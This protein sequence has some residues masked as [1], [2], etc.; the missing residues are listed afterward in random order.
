V[1]SDNPY[2]N[3]TNNRFSAFGNRRNPTTWAGAPTTGDLNTIAG[4]SRQG[5]TMQTWLGQSMGLNH[6]NGRVEDAILGRFLSPDP[7]IPDPSSAQSYNRYS[8]VNNNPVSMVD[9]SGFKATSTCAQMGICSADFHQGPVAGDGDSPQFGDQDFGE[10]LFGPTGSDLD[11]GY[12][13]AYVSDGGSGGGSGGGAGGGDAT[14]SGS[15]QPTDPAQDQDQDSAQSGGCVGS[16]C[17]NE[18]TVLASASTGSQ[19]PYLYGPDLGGG[20]AC[21]SGYCSWQLKSY[22]SGIDPLY[23]GAFLKLTYKGKG[24]QWVTTYT[25][26]DYPGDFLLPP[27]TDQNNPFYISAFNTS[28]V[29]WIQSGTNQSGFYL[30]EVSLVQPNGGGGY[31]AAFTVMWGWTW[32]QTPQGPVFFPIG[33]LIAPI[34]SPQQQNIG[35]LH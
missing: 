26:D 13:T 9:P 14:A 3:R 34:W 4:L 5:Y 32:A 12:W 6:M 21:G 10:D 11:G 18:V 24:G 30:G 1:R 19:F 22:I 31:S 35:K 16:P 17:L 33:P 29:F 7:H 20:F 28:N 25:G 8:Y 15:T 23:V 27:G 2:G